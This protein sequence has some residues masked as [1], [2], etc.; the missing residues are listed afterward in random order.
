MEAVVCE[1]VGATTMAAVT[2]IAAPLTIID[3]IGALGSVASVA[4]AFGG[5]PLPAYFVRLADR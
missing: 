2:G 3:V 5:R 1:I 4:G